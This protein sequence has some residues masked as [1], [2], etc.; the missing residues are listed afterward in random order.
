MTESQVPRK[1]GKYEIVAPLRGGGM[2]RVFRARDPRIGRDVAIKKLTEG[3]AGNPDMLKR[4]YQEAGHTGNLRHPNIV[5]IYDFG[6]EDGQPYIVME[7]LDGDPLDQLI[8]SN[9]SLH[10][11]EKL[12]IME[13]VCAAL[14]YAHTHGIIHRDVKPANIIVQKD[15]VAKLLDFGIARA[16][17]SH[18]DGGMTR[19]GTMV[20][21]PEYMAPERFDTSLI[22]DARSDI[23]SAGVVLFEI[24]TGT[25]PFP[26]KYPEVVSQI[27][28]QDPPEL[29]RYLQSYP[30]HLDRIMKQALA[31][32][33]Q[34]RYAHAGDMASDLNS[35][36][37]QL[38]RDR[39]AELLGEARALADKQDLAQAKILIRQVLRFDSQNAAAKGML[40]EVNLEIG[41]L[42]VRRRIEQLIAVAT[43][44]IRVHNWDH[45]ESACSEG[46]QLDT[47]NVDLVALLERVNAGRQM[48]EQILLFLR[49]AEIER[50]RGN[51]SAAAE[52][53]RQAQELDPSNSRVLALRREL[54]QEIE[55][56]AKRSNFEQ[57]LQKTREHLAAQRFPDAAN[58]I[59]MA[60]TL[61]GTDPELLLLKDQL[62]EAV[63]HEEKNRLVASLQEQIAQAVTLEQAQE[64]MARLTAALAVYFAEPTLMRL[65]LKLEPRLRDLQARRVIVEASEACRRLPSDEALIKIREALAQSPGNADL[66]KLEAVMVERLARQGRERWLAEYLSK[67]HAL[68][69]DNLYLETVKVLESCLQAGFSSP[70]IVELLDMAKSRAAERLSQ[71]LVERS[72]LDAKKLISEQDYESAIDLLGPVLA[73][74]N[75]PSLRALFEEATAKQTVLKQR[76]DRLVAEVQS[77]TQLGLHDAAACLIRD[78]AAGLGASKRVQDLSATT[79][80][81]LER[82]EKELRAIGGLYVNLDTPDCALAVRHLMNAQGSSQ[83]PSLVREIEKCLEA[84]VQ[85]IGDGHLQKAFEAARHALASDDALL[86]EDLLGG[87][88]GWQACSSPSLAADWK[89]IQAEISSVKKV[90]RFKKRSRS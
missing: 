9:A 28:H 18:I 79:A 56:Q 39:A 35:M 12:G 29:E 43:E 70:E 49:D 62:T 20:G 26:A 50:N 21:T 85:K 14:G 25:R 63:R 67:A 37:V 76:I 69:E 84:R 57:L 45:A 31:K 19:T 32:K 65:K 5:I 78:A 74:T 34:D 36:A 54:E 13:Q 30:Q 64:A 87:V 72:F 15:G 86:A 48:R 89:A 77:L 60:E 27:L 41:R 17:D 68:L 38:R 80:A 22:V 81:N 1:V 3:Y 24:L 75:E 82:E 58:A 73:R 23:F 53:A 90:L 61:D 44:A 16:D 83:D 11:S 71:E 47:G 40:Q 88:S 55:V 42:E 59:D 51:F 8:A 33:P 6:D 66:L 2:G 4:F 10:L 46:L 7:Y 52:K